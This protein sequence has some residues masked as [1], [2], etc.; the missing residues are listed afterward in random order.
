MVPLPSPY[1]VNKWIL[2]HKSDLIA[3]RKAYI[4]MVHALYFLTFVNV[5]LFS[6]GVFAVSQGLL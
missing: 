2:D 5:C 1:P 6:A 4:F 3:L